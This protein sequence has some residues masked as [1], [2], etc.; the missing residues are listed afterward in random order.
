MEMAMAKMPRDVTDAELAVLREL[1]SQA[2]ATIRELADRL[3]P[4]GSAAHY[5]TVQKLLE[6]MEGK[7]FVS[8]DT[9]SGSAHRFK[10]RVGQGE[11]IGRRLREMAEALCG[12][13]VGPLLT[14]L[15]RSRRLS[16]AEIG[17][18]RDLVDGLEREGKGKKG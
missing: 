3:Y 9:S 16:K 12:G 5:S 4:G 10:A 2:S 11:L 8:R 1:W 14:H 7:G 18:L 13:A 6:R 15:V 17:E